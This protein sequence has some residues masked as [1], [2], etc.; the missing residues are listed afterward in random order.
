MY[1]GVLEERTGKCCR[2]FLKYQIAIKVSLL[3]RQIIQKVGLDGWSVQ[4]LN[5]KSKTLKH[6]ILNPKPT[7]PKP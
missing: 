4:T 2:I 3:I 6:K 1:I 5:R 7:N